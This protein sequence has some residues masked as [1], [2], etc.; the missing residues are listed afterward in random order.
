MNNPL[1]Q[2]DG[3]S[4]NNQLGYSGLS[5]LCLNYI[6]C[7]QVIKSGN[8]PQSF[9]EANSKIQG[10]VDSPSFPSLFMFILFLYCNY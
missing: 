5:S 6:E 4:R 7:I 8:P 1:E 10:I 3:N 9:Q 2:S